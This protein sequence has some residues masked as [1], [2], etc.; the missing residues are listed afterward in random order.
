MITL[1][2]D[3][4]KVSVEE[5]ATVLD[6]AKLASV[7]IP[8]LCHCD[9]LSEYGGCRICMVEID[10]EPKL[11]ASCARPVSEGMVVKTNTPRVRKARKLNLELLLAAH[12]QDCLSCVR[13][14]TCELQQL[15][16]DFGIEDVRFEAPRPIYTVDESS[17]SIVRDPN[18]CILCGRCVRTCSEVQGVSVIEFTQRSSHS[19]VTPCFD[20]GIASVECVNCGQCIHGCPVGALKEKSSI[21]EVWA[22]LADP[23]KHVVVQEAPAVRVALGEEFGFEAGTLVVGKMYGAL[24]ALGFDAVFDTNFTADLTI[25]EEGNELIKRVTTG[26]VLPMIT[27][28]SPGWIKYLEHFYPDLTDN[29]ST[30]KSPQQMFGALVKT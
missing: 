24:R 14:K 27:S 4:K 25:I 1:T 10:K 2:I 3:N 13:N 18:K 29:L 5:G 9:G 30:C 21:E 22:A 12:P 8:T 16:A 20:E 6:A 11:A 7:K 15:A 26:G 23:T 19:K 28:C 17:A